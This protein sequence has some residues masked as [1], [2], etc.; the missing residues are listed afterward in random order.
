MAGATEQPCRSRANPRTRLSSSPS[1]LTTLVDSP[2]SAGKHYRTIELG[3]EGGAT[4]YLHLA[5]DSDRALEISP[6]QLESYKNLVKETGALF[7]SRHYRSYHFLYT[8]SDHVASFG[9]EHHES[10]DDRVGEAR[11]H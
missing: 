7:G 8:L 6:A 4:H 5:A 1:S 11:T 2:V 9:L 10:S 3:S